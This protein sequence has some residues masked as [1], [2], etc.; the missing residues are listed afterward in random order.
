MD[1]R[2]LAPTV[3]IGRRKRFV[4]KIAVLILGLNVAVA[5]NPPAAQTDPPRD[6]AGQWTGRC[7]RCPVKS[8]TL[9]LSQ[10]GDRLAGH[11]QA[12][13]RTGLGENEMT[14]MAGKVEGR[15]ITFR[16]IGADGIP[17]DSS[18]TVGSDGTTME[19]TG[20]HRAAFGLSFVRAG[21]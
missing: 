11:L 3:G 9:V 19:G 17:L 2:R 16:V 6:V 21:P 5:P 14:L 12:S 15:T 13:G 7:D 1:V 10:N 18:L 20:R 4:A 8:F